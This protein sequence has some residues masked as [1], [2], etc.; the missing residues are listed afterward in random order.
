MIDCGMN[1]EL[2]AFWKYIFFI[3]ANGGNLALFKTKFDTNLQA[4]FFV[5]SNLCALDFRTQK[6]TFAFIFNLIYL[7]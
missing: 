6:K 2:F 7:K 4:L 1:Y 5:I 3:F